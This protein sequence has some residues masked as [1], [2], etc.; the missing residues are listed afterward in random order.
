ML[1]VFGV[2]I[3]CFGGVYCMCASVK[4]FYTENLC[5]FLSQSHGLPC[6]LG[7][8]WFAFIYLF[9]PPSCVLINK[10][11]AC[12]RQYGLWS[13]CA[14]LFCCTLSHSETS[15]T[16]MYFSFKNMSVCYST[17]HPWGS[18]TLFCWSLS[19]S[20][21]NVMKADVAV[22]VVEATWSVLPVKGWSQSNVCSFSLWF[23]LY[24]LQR[25]LG[26]I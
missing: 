20:S 12:V 26:A 4:I 8:C 6:T 22:Y 24:Y 7:N 11:T 19:Q 14:T 25:M 21:M 5:C 17:V 18:V 1:L 9:F 13:I 3:I 23:S 15:S 2:C 10:I 16:S